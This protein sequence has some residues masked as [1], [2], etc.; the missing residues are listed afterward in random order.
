[1]EDIYEAR[2]V[3]SN[4]SLLE[5][6]YKAFNHCASLNPDPIQE[7]EGDFFFN[8]EEV[9]QGAAA[10]LAHL[11]S[12]FTM[13]SAQELDGLLDITSEQFEDAEDEMPDQ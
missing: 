13:P 1:M 4:P 6:M 9:Q 8:E 10:N 5:Q 3:P 12:V 11:E 2:F 7:D